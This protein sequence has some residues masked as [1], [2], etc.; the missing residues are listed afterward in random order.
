MSNEKW[1]VILKNIQLKQNFRLLITR[2][3]LLIAAVMLLPA[4]GY[5]PSSQVIK[6]T[7]TGKCSIC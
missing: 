3:S 6:N 7:F 1:R 4:C 2:Y 5:K